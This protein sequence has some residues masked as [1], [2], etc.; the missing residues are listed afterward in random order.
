MSIMFDMSNV[1][2]GTIDP[3][4]LFN[5]DAASIS[6]TDPAFSHEFL[7]SLH[8]QRGSISSNDGMQPYL[9]S[10]TPSLSPAS[11]LQVP[12]SPHSSSSPRS[13]FSNSGTDESFMH[14]Y[15]TSS[16]FDQ[17]FSLNPDV[18]AKPAQPFAFPTA[19]FDPDFQFNFELF[20]AVNQATQQGIRGQVVPADQ[21]TVPG[22]NAMHGVPGMPEQHATQLSLR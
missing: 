4:A 2:D 7:S 22:A 17:L 21:W 1:Y 20:N 9:S 5:Y 12:H 3:D 11:Q 13:V 10:S 6:P 16:A 18:Q 19:D 14:N 15:S 8:Q